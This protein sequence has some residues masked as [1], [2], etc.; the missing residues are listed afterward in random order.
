MSIV[1]YLAER[2]NLVKLLSITHP[3]NAKAKWSAFDIC[4]GWA[5]KRGYTTARFVYKRLHYLRVMGTFFY[6]PFENIEFLCDLPHTGALHLIV[7]QK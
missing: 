6:D 3:E 4:E 5:I 2:V 7:L 1:Q